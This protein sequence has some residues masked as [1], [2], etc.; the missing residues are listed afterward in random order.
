MLNTKK[1]IQ[2]K[3]YKQHNVSQNIVLL[4][5]PKRNL[6]TCYALSF[7]GGKTW[8]IGKNNK[9]L[10]NQKQGEPNEIIDICLKL[11]EESNNEK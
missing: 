10:Y 11:N 1:K 7:D 5:M 4:Y 3:G 6:N 9:T 2:R 8:N